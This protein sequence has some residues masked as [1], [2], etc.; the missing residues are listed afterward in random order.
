[1]PAVSLDLTGKWEFKQYPLSARQM[2]DLQ[3]SDWL[4]ADVPASIFTNLADAGLIKKSDLIANPEDF[5]YVSETPWIYRKIFD[6]SADILKCDRIDLVFDGLDT[7][8]AIWLNDKRIGKTTNMF[9]PFRFDITSLLKSSGNCLM[10]KFDPAVPYAQKL[11]AKYSHSGPKNPVDLYRT[12]IRKAQ[13][14]FGWD[15]CPALPGCGIWRPVHL[16]GIKKAAIK[17][18]NIRTVDCNHH[19]ADI[20]VTAALDTLVK[21]NFIC[22]LTLSCG[23]R[24]LIHNMTFR[25]GEKTHSTVIR[26]ENPSLWWPRGYGKQSLYTLDAQLLAGDEIADNV[27]KSFGIRNVRLEYSSDE[28][29]KKFQFEVNGQVIAVKGANWVPASVFAGS[30]TAD[31]YHELLTL[32][33]EANINMLRVWGGGYYEAD[34]FYKLCDRLGIM[35]WQDFMFAC[36]Y[37]PEEKCFIEEVKKEA[38]E[39]ITQL[40]NHPCLA[41]WCGNNEIDW[42]HSNGSLGKSKKFYGR[43]IYHNLLPQLVTDMD[44]DTA[45]IPTTPFTGKG[46]FKTDGFL[47]THQWDIWWHNQPVSNYR[48]PSEAVPY[49]VTEFGIQSMP[50]IK[51]IQSLCSVDKFRV[52]SCAIEKHNYQTDGGNSR[53]YRYLSDLFG[54]AKNVE[55]LVYL[56][57]LTQA[58]AAKIYV[59][60]LRAHGKKNKGILFWQFNDSFPAISW[61]AVDHNKNPKAIYYYARRFFAGH[62]IAALPDSHKTSQEFQPSGIVVINDSPQSLTAQLNCRL[63][64][65]HGH[66]HDRITVPVS[67]APFSS[68]TLFKLPK[69]IASPNN[70]EKLCL[71]ILLEKDD[72]RISENLF[73][74]LPDKYIDWP[75]AEITKQFSKLS[76]N[77][78]KLT[79]KSNVITK[80]VQIKPPSLAKL[81][82][83]YI[84]LM[85]ASEL[86]I[87][88]ISAQQTL[89]LIESQIN[90][91]SVNSLFNTD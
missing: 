85:P 29:D 48:C 52:G 13:Y 51:T 41:I 27:Q 23:D 74:Y 70:P 21:E 43:T 91:C 82:D 64:D 67:I 75:K 10:V 2:S 17:N 60:H 8:A 1:M 38:A 78:W 15:F 30:V 34:E 65:L 26:I 46:G 72:I 53:L 57:Q 25:H 63:M 16:E 35:V 14:Q 24:I 12:Y 3:S 5:S 40:R 47:T 73:F 71:H 50:D 77:R 39:I 81:S 22:K 4:P 20:K 6:V 84:D 31:D 68:S 59:E 76:D 87:I 32:A 36:A 80:D 11:M 86:D 44:P 28:N 49:F 69:A 19:Y 45:Y 18:I 56:S 37:Y 33:A 58:R 79:L 62:L 83:N 55:Q 54:T 42:K 88:I 90:I 89:S 7:V 9:I 61:S 66:H